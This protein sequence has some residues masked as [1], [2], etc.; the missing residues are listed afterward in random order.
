MEG[1]LNRIVHSPVPIL[2]RLFGMGTIR[3]ALD[4]AGVEA[5]LAGV[6]RRVYGPPGLAGYE[7]THRPELA[8]LARRSL[9]QYLAQRA[10]VRSAPLRWGQDALVLLALPAIAGIL[11]L[12][13]LAEARRSG[14]SAEPG[15]VV[16]QA[17]ESLRRL[18]EP[19]FADER[20][21]YHAGRSPWLGPAEVGF[22]LRLF[23]RCPRSLLHPRYVAIQL[24][25]VAYLGGLVR[26]HRPRSV[27][28]CI[29]DSSAS[30]VLTAFL[31]ERGIA[32]RNQMHGEKFFFPPDAFAEFDEF[33]V[34]GEA[35]RE[36]YEAL[37]IRARF[38]ITGNPVHRALFAGP[39]GSVR[40]A[41]ILIL[42]SMLLD[43]EATYRDSLL[44]LL[45]GLPGPWRVGVRLHYNELEHGARF[46]ARLRAEGVRRG[47]SF[48]IEE[49]S[50]RSPLEE[51]LA[52]ARVA[53]G[54]QSTALI[55]AWVA[56]CRVVHLRGASF[57][58]RAILE[59][60]GGSPNVAYLDEGADVAAFLSRPADLDAVEDRR[61]DRLT[62]V[63][64]PPGSP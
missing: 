21:V 36:L 47:W 53:V 30:S 10:L 16:I 19:V 17:T 1:A 28:S 50:H 33:G 62:S 20:P 59:R 14:G 54:A 32:H 57:G 24:R 5:I 46:L 40:P 41:T 8:R 49:R 13:S 15:R 11:A 42:H 58:G 35:F 51:D 45:S 7:A 29:E 34:W 48:E 22:L 43:A 26:R 63:L 2:A 12:R 44:E 39:R 56:G 9:A 23:G 3:R 18:V 25:H 27:V 4:R 61:V 60:Y 37:R 55:D 64:A 52:W 38:R 6:E 31:R